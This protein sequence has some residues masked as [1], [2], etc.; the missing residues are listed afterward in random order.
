MHT[1]ILVNR[2]ININA[3]IQTQKV[4]IKTYLNKSIHI[5]KYREY[6]IVKQIHIKLHTQTELHKYIHILTP[7]HAKAF[8]LF[9]IPKNTYTYTITNVQTLKHLPIQVH[10][11]R[12][13]HLHTNMHT[14]IHSSIYPSI[15]RYIHPY[16]HAHRKKAK[17]HI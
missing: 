14:S 3:T 17:Q 8:P 2:Q 16:T 6:K 9:F 10:I 13:T 15:H 11:N 12:Y 7:I 4:N 1:Q 5:L